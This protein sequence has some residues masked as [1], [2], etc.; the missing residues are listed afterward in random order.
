MIDGEGV[1]A[2]DPRQNRTQSFVEN[3][4]GGRGRAPNAASRTKSGAF[5]ETVADSVRT[6]LRVHCPASEF[7]V[8]VVE[9]CRIARIVVDTNY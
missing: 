4:F 3:R 6:R 2:F 5:G 8:L 1:P 9:I 7:S